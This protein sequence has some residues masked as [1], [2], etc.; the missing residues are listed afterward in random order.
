MRPN[1]V[2]GQYRD[3]D[4]REDAPHITFSKLNAYQPF[5]F[6]KCYVK[7]LI[8]SLKVEIENRT[9]QQERMKNNRLK[10]Q[11]RQREAQSRGRGL[12]GSAIAPDMAEKRLQAL[13]K[14]RELNALRKSQRGDLNMY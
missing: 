14:I 1:S 11:Q 10:Q 8:N 5:S 4:N 13:Q 9:I 12:A 3:D 2:L 6:R 7:L